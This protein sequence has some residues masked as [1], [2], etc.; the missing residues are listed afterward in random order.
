MISDFLTADWGHLHDD[1]RCV[2]TYLL[3]LN[4][5]RFLEK[6][7]LFSSQGRCHDSDVGTDYFLF[8][9]TSFPTYCSLGV[10]SPC[11]G[12]GLPFVYSYMLTRAV[13]Y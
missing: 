7:A 2:F 4:S 13:R 10:L 6:H 1:D 9:F 3:L 11:A 8:S 5:H 12:C